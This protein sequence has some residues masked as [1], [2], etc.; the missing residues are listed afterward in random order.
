MALP[1]HSHNDGVS[2]AWQVAICLTLVVC[3]SVSMGIY[4]V[5][6]NT[7]IDKQRELS[8]VYLHDYDKGLGGFVVYTDGRRSVDSCYI[9]NES[10]STG[11]DGA[12]DPT[13]LTAW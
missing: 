11:V 1:M 4:I 3:V 2:Y 9:V 8:P 12:Q 7:Q 10:E 5:R 13:R 6:L